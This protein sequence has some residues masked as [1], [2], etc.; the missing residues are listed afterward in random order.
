M[1]PPTVADMVAAAIIRERDNVTR[2]LQAA[3]VPDADVEDIAQEVTILAVTTAQA[4]R[5]AWKR[6]DTLRRWLFVV[7]YRH[8]LGHLQ[9]A[10]VRI[11]YEGTHEN[12]P[13]APSAEDRYLVR[14][15]LAIAARS[16]TPE[17][18]RCLRAWANG[19]DVGEIARR[20]RLT[21]PGVYNRIRLARRDI[22]ADMAREDAASHLRRRN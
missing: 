20:E 22:R 7:A 3:G 11:R 19:H 13:I 8:A 1:K 9:R 5:V 6:R 10:Q 15:T 14:E 21:V 4:E 12:E 18:W 2:T 17:R 16:T